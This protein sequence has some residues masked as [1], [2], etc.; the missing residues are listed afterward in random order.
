MKNIK[1]YQN[2]NYVVLGLTIKEYINKFIE[3]NYID[4]KS[5]KNCTDYIV[6]QNNFD[7]TYFVEIKKDNILLQF[8]NE[9]ELKN[10]IEQ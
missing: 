10:F 4:E 7:S 5:I 3:K 2:Y 8:N 1:Q 6:Y 9:I